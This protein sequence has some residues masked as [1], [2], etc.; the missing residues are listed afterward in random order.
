MTG[1]SI[2]PPVPRMLN[3]HRLMIGDSRTLYP[4]QNL[5]V[6]PPLRH[7]LVENPY[8]T[9]M[10]SSRHPSVTMV[11]IRRR[12]IYLPPAPIHLAILILAIVKTPCL[13]KTPEATV[14][15]LGTWVGLSMS[16][17]RNAPFHWYAASP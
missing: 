7:H 10:T 9:W 11:P 1:F 12:K 2:P 3:H 17:Q 14:I 5:L 13:T 16:R 4:V 8:W 6:E 15:F